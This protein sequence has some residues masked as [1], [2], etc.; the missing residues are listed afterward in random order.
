MTDLERAAELDRIADEHRGALTRE[1]FWAEYAVHMRN[2]YREKSRD[3]ERH[4][5][6]VGAPPKL[7]RNQR[8]AA[9]RK[10]RG[11]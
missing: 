4:L 7:T 10:A 11:K 8:K 5:T 2:A 3:V 9:R 1:Q 6:L